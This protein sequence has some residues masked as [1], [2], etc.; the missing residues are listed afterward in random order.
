MVAWSY[1]LKNNNK[2]EEIMK[3]HY[4]SEAPGKPARVP[5]AKG[6]CISV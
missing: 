1:N 6:L 2:F 5:L 4:S 3:A